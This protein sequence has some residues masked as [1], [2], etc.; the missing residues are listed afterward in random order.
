M[1]ETL[2]AWNSP[3]QKIEEKRG[4][5]VRHMSTYFISD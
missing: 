3:L 5:N 4:L 2:K 1:R